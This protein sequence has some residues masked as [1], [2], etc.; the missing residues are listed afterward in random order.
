MRSLCLA[1]ALAAAF[2]LAACGGSG[3]SST[4]GEDVATF[5]Q[6]EYPFT[7]EY[8]AGLESS[9]DVSFNK[10]LGGGASLDNTALGIDDSNAL[11]IQHYALDLQVTE[12]NIDQAKVELDALLAQI[13]PGASAETGQIGG[14]PSLS[15]EAI[16]V[17][18][19]PD[20][21][22]RITAL[23]EGDQEY[24]LN[25]QSTPEFRDEIDAACDQ[26]LATLAPG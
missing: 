9:D 14:F 20:G 17:S 2:A 21:E 12:E 16:T 13:D 8:P 22:S 26:A 10:Q 3:G 23:F 4:D 11:L 19:P 7:F 15:Y 24:Y 1:T 18:E 6:D 5:A 25:C